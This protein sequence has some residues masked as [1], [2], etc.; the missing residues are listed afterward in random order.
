MGRTQPSSCRSHLVTAL[1][2][3]SLLLRGLYRRTCKV[4]KPPMTQRAT[5]VS[6]VPKH[7]IP[8]WEKSVIGVLMTAGILA[9]IVYTLTNMKY[10]T[11]N[12]D[13]LVQWNEEQAARKEESE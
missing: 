9:P 5:V 3:S 1:K 12:Y 2:M 7:R 8:F 6:G 4:L 11:G 13:K 10:Y